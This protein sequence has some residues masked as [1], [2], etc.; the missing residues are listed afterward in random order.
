MELYRKY[1][2]KKFIDVLGQPEAISI[3]SRFVKKENVP[4]VILFHGPSGTGKTTLARILATKLKCRG[5]DLIEKNCADFR[6]ID[7]IREIRSH[8]SHVPIMGKSRVWIIDES[9]EL[10][11][12]A[13]NAFLKILEEPPNHAYFFLATTEPQKLLKTIR[14]RCTEIKTQLLD[15]QIMEELINSICEKEKEKVTTEVRDKIIEVADGSARKALVILNQIIGLDDEEVQLSAIDAADNEKQAVELARAL[16][17]HNPQWKDISKL[18]KNIKEEPESIRRLVLAY[19]AGI[20]INGGLVE[21]C[22]GIID[23]FG[24]NY[25]DSGKAGLVWSAYQCCSKPKKRR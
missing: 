10:G 19:V 16:I 4:H 6:G 8:I 13:Q 23:A 7:T 9:G 5:K 14:T 15:F 1:R 20:A 2:P 24:Q 11:R 3:L 12:P 22:I 21:K 25:F 17:S 18:I